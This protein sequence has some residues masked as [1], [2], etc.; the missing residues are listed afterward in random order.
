M[1]L[2]KS[3]KNRGFTLTE[4]MIAIGIGSFILTTLFLSATALR[5]SLSAVDSYFSTHVQQIRIVDYLSRDVKRSTIVHSADRLTIQCWIPKYVVKATD[6]D[7]IANPALVGTR[8]TPVIT[9]K[10]N[11]YKVDYGTP[12][13]AVSPPTGVTEVDYYLSGGSIVRKEDGVVTTIASST[14]QLI[15]DFVDVES[16]NTEYSISAVTFLPTFTLN[17][18]TTNDPRRL[19]TAVYSLAYLRNLRRGN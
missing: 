9:N 4:L 10:Q 18:G 13:Y 8:R 5:K 2:I 11:V 16:A 12:N 6:P 1:N 19:G 3:R 17:S 7:G 15:P 14:D